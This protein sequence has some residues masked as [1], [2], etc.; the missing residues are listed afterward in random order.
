VVPQARSFGF[1]T[2]SQAIIR[3]FAR[4]RPD[5]FSLPIIRRKHPEMGVFQTPGHGLLSRYVRRLFPIH[6]YPEIL[7]P[8]SPRYE[9]E[10]GAPFEHAIMIRLRG[11]PL[12][13]SALFSYEVLGLF[14]LTR[15]FCSFRSIEGQRFC[16]GLSCIPSGDGIDMWSRQGGWLA[17]PQVE[18]RGHGNR[19]TSWP[20]R[21]VGLKLR[22][23]AI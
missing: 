20:W 16:G 12:N 19:Y 4:A 22:Q 9:V 10:K 5:G 18:I 3:L 14:P 1:P 15:S 13:R 23:I 21:C 7:I 6:P 17:I 11:M 8:A 2:A